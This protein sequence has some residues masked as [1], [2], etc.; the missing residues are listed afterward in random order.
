[1][2]GLGYWCGRRKQEECGEPVVVRNKISHSLAILEE[3]MIFL[4]AAQL[5]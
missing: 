5:R 4:V 3:E 2:R 1:M